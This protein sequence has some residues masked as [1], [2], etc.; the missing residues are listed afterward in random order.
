MGRAFSFGSGARGGNELLEELK[1]VPAALLMTFV[2]GKKFANSCAPERPV[3]DCF[4]W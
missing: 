3:C 1:R 4:G 2:P